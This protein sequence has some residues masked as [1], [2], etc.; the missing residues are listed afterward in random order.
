EAF[1]ATTLKDVALHAGVSIK[2]A[3]NVVNG[4]GRMSDETR[5]RVEAALIELHYQPNLPARYLR[6]S[7]VGVLTLAI[8]DFNSYFADIGDEIISAASAVGYTVLIDHTRG[9]R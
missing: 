1:M 9:M 8:P 2:T 4:L 7:T 3:S 5:E 6:H